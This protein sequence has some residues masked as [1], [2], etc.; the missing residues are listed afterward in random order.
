MHKSKK[1]QLTIYLTK[2]NRV[3][4]QKIA[5]QK[6]MENPQKNFSAGSVAAEL[7]IEYLDNLKTDNN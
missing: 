4:L 3:Q 5:A 2:E 7:L 1:T 6:M